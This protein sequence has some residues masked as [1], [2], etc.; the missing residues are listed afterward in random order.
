MMDI[1][2]TISREIQ[3][4]S[5]RRDKLR[6]RAHLFKNELHDAWQKIEAHWPEI[7]MKFKELDKPS[8]G[9]IEEIGKALKSLLTE[10]KS[11][12]RR[13]EGAQPKTEEAKS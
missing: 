1:K 7:E 5:T 10:I 13:I 3:D 4:L 9:A 11:E 2:E 8:L 12:F 6:V